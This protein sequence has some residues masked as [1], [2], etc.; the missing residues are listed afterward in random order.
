VKQLEME[1]DCSQQP[2]QRADSA[3]EFDA[4]GCPSSCLQSSS[5]SAQGL[6]VPRQ[7]PAG[8][9]VLQGLAVFRHQ[10]GGNAPLYWHSG[11]ICKPLIQAELRFYAQLE[12]DMPAFIP[13][14]P[15]FYGQRHSATRTPAASPLAAMS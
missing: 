1:T 13:F 6:Q 7:S 4:S 10:V 12:T 5:V 11:T 2:A 14:V 15:K 8:A 3:E 9:A